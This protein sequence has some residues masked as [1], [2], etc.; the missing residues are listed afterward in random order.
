MKFKA[1][2]AKKDA[3]NNIQSVSISKWTLRLSKQ[4]MQEEL[5]TYFR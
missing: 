4:A 3:S 2:Q 5:T 1:Q